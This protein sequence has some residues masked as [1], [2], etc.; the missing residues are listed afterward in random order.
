MTVRRRVPWELYGL[1]I[2]VAVFAIGAVLWVA[3]PEGRGDVRS[4]ETLTIEAGSEIEHGI[5]S[6][7]HPFLGSPA[8]PVT[9]I[10]IGDFQCPFCREFAVDAFDSFKSGFVADGTV[11]WVWYS[12]GFDGDESMAAAEAAHCAALQDRFWPMH[13]WLYANA[14]IVIDG[15]AFSRDR[16]VEIA[17]RVGLDVPAFEK[18]LDDPAVRQTVLDNESFARQLGVGATP[19]FVVGDRLVEG[20]DLQGLR[21]V[22]EAA[23]GE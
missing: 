4:P 19:T 7:G 13:D 21:A 17:G 16:L 5:T 3:S 14:S 12:V 10:E 11:R 22:I 6:D 2:V 23:A 20:V 1:L 18:C 8:A 9:V 15:G